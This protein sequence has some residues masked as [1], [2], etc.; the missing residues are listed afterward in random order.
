VAVEGTRIAATG[1]PGAGPPPEGEVPTEWLV[2]WRDGFL[3]GG[4][5]Y[6]AQPSPVEISEETRALFPQEIV[7]LFPDGMPATLDEAGDVLAEAG[8]LDEA[9]AILG[10]N[11]S[12]RAEVYA[13]P[14]GEPQLVA[15]YS[16]D[17][18]QWEPVDIA[19]PPGLD[20]VQSVVVAGDRLVAYGLVD[21]G[22][23]AEVDAAA[24]P[25]SIA[26]VASTT[27][28][29]EWSMQT[30]EPA[31]D[32]AVQAIARVGVNVDT[33]AANASGWVAAVSSYPDPD[34][35]SLLPDTV[36]T[37][38]VAGWGT[39]DTGLQ[40]DIGDPDGETT[41]LHFSWEELG[42]DDELRDRLLGGDASYWHGS[43]GGAV[44]EVELTDVGP[45]GYRPFPHLAAT[46]AGFVV[47]SDVVRFSPDGLTWSSSPAPD[48]AV[49]GV[50]SIGDGLILFADR[51][52]LT[53]VYRTDATGGDWR[54]IEVP[55]APARLT[56]TFGSVASP[57]QVL[58]SYV[59]PPYVGPEVVVEHEGY[60]LTTQDSSD[61]TRYEL[62]D[63][64]SGELASS[65]RVDAGGDWGVT[66]P[67]QF[68]RYEERGIVLLDPDT[69]AE[70]VVVPLEVVS[71]AAEAAWSEQ[72]ETDGPVYAPDLWVV[73][74][75]DGERW[76]V[77][78]LPDEDAEEVG[79]SP[80]AAINGAVVLARTGTDWVR[81]DLG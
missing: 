19:M 46:D 74:T 56:P 9:L 66:G 18:R 31:V 72:D 7:D 37:D 20:W 79:S 61:A 78:D 62:V 4:V 5:S 3:T 52:D 51:S 41:S 68:L 76:L 70:L 22:A 16:T 21:P 40:V 47:V 77:E 63:L 80:V 58:D 23:D 36:D 26:A 81:Y 43:W 49:T 6:P 14:A 67:F 13:V 59:P 15:W 75:P 44:T 73:A 53:T 38:D 57:A 48:S 24:R 25:P 33:V 12:A 2:P 64:G 11:E 71:R 69:G 60:R 55:D 50:M 17:G 35:E 45:A 29:V 54:E 32:P 27:D 65:E 28:L 30:I 1:G 39:S 34:F 42:I 10:Q 8:L